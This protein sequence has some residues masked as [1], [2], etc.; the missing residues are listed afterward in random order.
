MNTKNEDG[1]ITKHIITTPSEVIKPSKS[2]TTISSISHNT[3]PRRTTL[4]NGKYNIKSSYSSRLP[5][6]KSTS[7]IYLRKRS[8]GIKHTDNTE[9]SQ[10]TE[11]IRLTPKTDAV[12]E[13]PLSEHEEDYSTLYDNII[14][15]LKTTFIDIIEASADKGANEDD[16]VNLLRGQ[17]DLQTVRIRRLER[18]LREKED[19]LMKQK[20]KYQQD[21]NQ[22]TLEDDDSAIP[23]LIEKYPIAMEI[24]RQQIEEEDINEQLETCIHQFEEQKQLM[25][26]EYQRHF[27]ALK[28]KYRSRFDDVVERMISDPSRLDDEWA[29]RIQ[30]S[31]NDRIKEME[32]YYLSK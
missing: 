32:R 25:I 29:R 28:M 1:N 18:A 21:I 27:E 2:E 24:Y 9:H 23:L 26:E 31:A 7:S 8:T 17:F 10:I 6:I 11:V 5:S 14:S 12:K 19:Q 13:Q 30:K 16:V 4:D 20:E 3:R 15:K 22:L